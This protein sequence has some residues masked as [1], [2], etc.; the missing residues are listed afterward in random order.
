MLGL[1]DGKF[2]KSAQGMQVLLNGEPAAM[3]AIS[4]T[5]INFIAHHNVNAEEEATLQLMYEDGDEVWMSNPVTMATT[6]RW[7][8][9][10]EVGT[11][12]AAATHSGGNMTPS[13]PLP[14]NDVLVWYLAGAGSL[15]DDS[16]GADE[17]TPGDKAF[18]FPAPIPELHAIVD[19][20]GVIELSVDYFGNS[21][22]STPGLGQMNLRFPQ[23]F[24][25]YCAVS[26][27][28]EFTLSVHGLAPGEFRNPLGETARSG[29]EAQGVARC[30]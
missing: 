27:D 29:V 5:Q 19:G 30:P 12:F 10:F 23:E 16:I 9:L 20:I 8:N 3:T 26:K 1:V 14:E 21:P 17:L 7:A 18:P 6:D 28:V 24:W 13:N 25:D 22:G 15:G 4:G 2:P 11:G